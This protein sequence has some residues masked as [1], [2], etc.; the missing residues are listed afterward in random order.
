ME[1]LDYLENGLDE[2]EAGK[3]E[4]ESTKNKWAPFAY[5]TVGGRDYKLKLST[6]VICQLE[7]KFKANLL[8]LISTN[9]DLPPL[10]VML[11]IIQGAMK[12]WEHG[13]KYEEVQKL[14]DTYCNEGGSQIKLLE[15]VV[16]K[17]YEVSG[18]F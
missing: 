7:A 3:E 1:N 5:W 16:L 8:S 18:F 15:E 12:E 9:K 13:I 2:I 10:A 4:S 14:F 6:A 11:T 17:I